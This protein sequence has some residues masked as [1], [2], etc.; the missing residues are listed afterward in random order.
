MGRKSHFVICSRGESG[1][2]G[3]PAERSREARAS[4]KILGA[5]VQFL[6]LGGAARGAGDGYLE[7]RNSHALKIAEM[8]RAVK[9]SIVLAPTPMPNQHPDHCALG[10]LARN[11]ARLARYGGIKELRRA[12][13]HA[14]E[15]LLFYAIS[16]DAEMQGTMP[17]LIDVSDANTMEVWTRAMQ[18]HKSQ[19]KTRNYLELQ[20]NRARLNGQRAGISHAIAL[21]ANDA[22]LFDSLRGV[23]RSARSF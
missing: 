19:M 20:L 6:D 3:T 21:F 13:A 10:T 12:P 23:S 9:P 1:S 18:A 7:S 16:P 14:I 4:A 2:H 22:I 17:I 5:S 8:I 15:V 11:A